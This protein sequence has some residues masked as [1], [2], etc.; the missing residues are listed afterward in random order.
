MKS[1]TK[2]L[3]PDSAP[4]ITVLGSWLVDGSVCADEEFP[5]EHGAE[6]V[7]VLIGPGLG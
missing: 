4:L 2:E 6:N 1:G 7:A 5:S 3:F